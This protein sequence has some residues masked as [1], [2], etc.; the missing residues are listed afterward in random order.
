M[1]HQNKNNNGQMSTHIPVLLEAVLTYLGPEKG[2]TYLDAT[3]GYGGHARAILE[4]TLQDSDSVL[5]D[6]DENAIKA[7]SETFKGRSVQIEK[8]NFVSAAR[9]LVEKGKSFDIILADLGVSSEHL[10]NAERGF[11]IK[12]PGPLDMRMDQSREL[13]AKKI[14]NEWSKDELIEILQT[15]GEEYKARRI[16]ESIVKGRPIETTDQLAGIVASAMSGKRSKV[17]PATKTFQAIRVAVNNEL[18]ML[19]EA[20]PLWVNLLKPGG[21]LGIITFHSLEDRIVKEFFKEHAFDG[22]D[23]ELKLVTKKAVGP[24]P[25]EIVFNPRSRSAKLRVAAKIKNKERST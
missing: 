11:S 10:D 19:Q 25:Q 3:A 14:V 1:D 20:L 17:H 4:K 9:E 8:N 22:Y 23:A 16:V 6:Q 5:I 21:R 12:N 2:S 18:G 13:T 7:L 24:E 15:Y